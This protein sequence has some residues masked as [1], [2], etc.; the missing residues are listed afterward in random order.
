VSEQD[1]PS[2]AAIRISGGATPRDIAAIVSVLSSLHPVESPRGPQRRWG[3][4]AWDLGVNPLLTP[5]P[6]A[7]KASSLPRD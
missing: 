5:G 4:P 7:W 2:A 3:S 1:N 6:G